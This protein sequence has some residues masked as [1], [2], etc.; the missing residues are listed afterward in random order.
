AYIARRFSAI[1]RTHATASST[2]ASGIPVAEP[3]HTTHFSVVDARGMAVA[4]TFTLNTDF[5]A[6]VQIPDTGITLNNEMDDFAAKPGV[7]NTFGLVQGERNSIAP[8]KRMLSSMTPTLVL[9]GDQLRAVVGSPGGP[10]ITTTVAQIL[11]QII[12]H[13]RS[14]REAVEAPRVHQQWLPDEVL[15]EPGLAPQLAD[16]LRQR[17]HELV[18]ESHIGHA[19]CIELDREHR[20]LNAV[21]DVNR[22][23]GG[24]AVY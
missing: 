10:T 8:G 18:V 19:H 3:M 15:V 23:G 5:G 9:Q 7:A 1:D 14:L 6:L 17:G 13:G 12:D 24:V 16:A 11:M 2:I 4:N 22:G 21:A 20:T